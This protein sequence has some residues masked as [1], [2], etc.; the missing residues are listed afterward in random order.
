M[1]EEMQLVAKTFKGLED[2]LAEE[3]RQLG[4]GN[5]TPGTRMVS[6]TGDKRML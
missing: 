6:F 2:V 5:V 1:K 4:A 3:L